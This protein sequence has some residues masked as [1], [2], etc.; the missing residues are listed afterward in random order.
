MLCV[1]SLHQ[2]GRRIDERGWHQDPDVF[3]GPTTAPCDPEAENS[4][5]GQH[6]DQEPSPDGHRATGS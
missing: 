5:K 1:E 4:Q 6:H 3:N 2:G